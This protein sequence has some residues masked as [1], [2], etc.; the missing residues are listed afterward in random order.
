MAARQAAGDSGNPV[1]VAAAIVFTSPH[2]PSNITQPRPEPLKHTWHRLTGS[3][4][5]RI[6]AKVSPKVRL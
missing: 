6:H 4:V 1:A 3:L 5:A 2:K